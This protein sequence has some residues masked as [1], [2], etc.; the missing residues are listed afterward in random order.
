MKDLRRH[1]KQIKQLYLLVE[2][3][4]PTLPEHLSSYPVLCGVHGAQCMGFD[5]IHITVRDI[6]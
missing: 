3:E 4:L 2:Q 6:A 1:I 5:Y